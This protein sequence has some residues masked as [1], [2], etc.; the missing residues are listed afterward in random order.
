MPSTPLTLFFDRRDNGISHC[1]CV[2]AWIKRRHDDRRRSDIRILRDRQGK[3]G[4]TAC[5]H[6]DDRQHRGENWTVD[7]KI[8]NHFFSSFDVCCVGDEAP[9]ADGN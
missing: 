4:D 7:E 6:K 2:G 5:Q 9:L 1:Q 3:N 8:G